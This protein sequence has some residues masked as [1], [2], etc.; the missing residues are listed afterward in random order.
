MTVGEVAHR[1]ARTSQL[2]N[3]NNLNPYVRFQGSRDKSRRPFAGSA[4]KLG[5]ESWFPG[6]NGA[7]KCPG[8]PL[9]EVVGSMFVAK[10]SERL[11]WKYSSSGLKENGEIDFVKIPE[12]ILPDN[13]GLYFEVVEQE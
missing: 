10:L 9:A 11:S 12:K 4:S 6:G 3:P 1:P 13:F 2:K 5:P 8:V 7:H